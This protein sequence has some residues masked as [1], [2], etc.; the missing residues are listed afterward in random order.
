MKGKSIR[1]VAHP[2]NERLLMLPASEPRW[3]SLPDFC[4]LNVDVTSPRRPSRKMVGNIVGEA[5]YHCYIVD[6]TDRSFKGY[7]KV[8]RELVN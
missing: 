6:G 8:G 2:P 7:L 4:I 3:S 5:G 1:T